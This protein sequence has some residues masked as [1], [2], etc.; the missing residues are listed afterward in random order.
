[1]GA[2][3]SES[4]ETQFNKTEEGYR[5]YLDVEEPDVPRLLTAAGQENV[6]LLYPVLGV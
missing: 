6:C 5:L 1:M 2:I 4:Q 3:A